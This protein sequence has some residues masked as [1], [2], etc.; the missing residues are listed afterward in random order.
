MGWRDV[1]AGVASGAINY[2]KSPDKFGSFL[3]GFA[4]TYA[5]GVQKKADRDYA[6]K[7]ATDK[8][9]AEE[10]KEAKKLREAREQEDKG[11]SSCS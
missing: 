6:D 2:R 4:T 3:E 1:Q 11:Q 10:L 7:L 8:L 5:A 9:K